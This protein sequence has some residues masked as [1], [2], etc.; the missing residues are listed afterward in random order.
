MPHSKSIWQ[1]VA[2]DLQT[3]LRP[4]EFE[5]WF[6]HIS[7]KELDGSSVILSVPNKYIA[8]WL[9][10]QYRKEVEDSFTKIL[11][12]PVSVSFRFPEVGSL[13]DTSK[14]R[15]VRSHNLDPSKTLTSFHTGQWNRFAFSSAVKIAEK[16]D[17]G[18]EPLYVYSRSGLGKTHLL[19][20][21]GNRILERRPGAV[22]HYLTS[23]MFSSEFIDSSR[24]DQ[25]ESFY[26]RFGDAQVILFDDL[27]QLS[28]RP[29][30]QQAFLSLFDHI[31]SE[32]RTM[33]LA[34][35]TAPHR[36]VN[37]S[38]ALM[39]RA[40]SGIIAEIQSPDPA[41]LLSLTR[42][43]TREDRVHLP[44]DVLFFLSQS[45]SDI[46]GLFKNIA[47]IETYTSITGGNISLS[48]AKS[49]VKGSGRDGLNVEDI[50]SIAASYFNISQKDLVSG[51]KRK[52][53]SYPRQ[54]AMYLARKHTS[55]SLKEIGE[56]FGH[57]DHST[58]LYAIRQ[59]EKAKTSG[60]A[61][62]ADLT[63]MENLLC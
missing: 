63:R 42:K 44:E 48:M 53:Q 55:L 47:K 9:E 14:D 59:V 45:C 60:S 3:R 25:Y 58:V 32:K 18:Y 34:A 26:V 19:H 1:R 28:T 27:H 8:S 40:A 33:V 17:Y 10:D 43:K 51:Q 4:S 21:I 56:A 11:K 54:I 52:C 6:A 16:D 50:K 30:T 20:G 36:L 5:I 62:V 15:G 29:K 49:L 23:S 12:H 57:R 37:M 2:K 41:S 22:V 39:S 61:M 31:V 35:D 46:R 24:K 7:L 13:D 38:P